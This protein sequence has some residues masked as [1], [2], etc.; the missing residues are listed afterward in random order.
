[1]PVSSQ[2]KFLK[3]SEHFIREIRKGKIKDKFPS[4][5]EIA[6]DFSISKATASRVLHHLREEG[7]IETQ[8]G[9][10]SMVRQ[11]RRKFVIRFSSDRER[12]KS[13]EP[14]LMAVLSSR[15]PDVDFVLD[16]E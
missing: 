8:V 9:S 12:M 6:R 16:M 13:A 2:N 14:L 1:M 10:G 11:R 15:F 5:N 3:I 4:E 7:F